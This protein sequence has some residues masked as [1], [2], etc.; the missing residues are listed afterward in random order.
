[1]VAEAMRPGRRHRILLQWALE[2][3]GALQWALEGAVQ[4]ALQGALLQ[5]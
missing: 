3:G 4:L 2:H 5:E 1:V